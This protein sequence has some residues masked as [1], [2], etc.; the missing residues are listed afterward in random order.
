MLG[1]AATALSGLVMLAPPAVAA[2]AP[3]TDRV[4][5]TTGGF[6]AGSGTGR[7]G[8]ASRQADALSANGRY[9]VIE[10]SAPLTPGVS[11]AP[12]WH[13]FVRDRKLGTTTLASVGHRGQAANG[14]SGDAVISADGR[15]VAFLSEATNLVPGD[16]NARSDVFLRDL[17]RGTTTRVSTSSTGGQLTL[18]GNGTVGASSPAISPDGRYVGFISAASGLTADDETG[19]QAYLKDTVTGALEVVSR[20][21]HGVPAHVVTG[22]SL[23]VS[24]GGRK[25]SFYS[26]DAYLVPGENNHNPD[27]FVRDRV[28]GAT[29]IV[30]AGPNGS[31]NP[32][33]NADGTHVAFIARDTPHLVPGAPAGIDLVYVHELASG[34]TVAASRS[35]AGVWADAHSKGP[36]LSHDGRFVSFNSFAT[37]L[38]P[39]DTNGEADVFRHDTTTGRTIRVSVRSNG[40]QNSLNSSLAAISGNG[41]HVLFES[42]ARDLTQVATTGW[43][44]V[45]VRSVDGSLPAMNARVAALPSRMARKS[46][47]KVSVSGI[48]AGQ[49]LRVVW[50]SGRHKKVQNIPVRARGVKIVA[51]GRAGKHKVSVTYAGRVLRTRTIVVR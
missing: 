40:R 48:A 46:S 39:A 9:V 42:H 7:L 17:R 24:R 19:S 50:K 3:F 20:D 45:F 33:M 26:L 13:I 49:K 47:R 5:V 51:P 38:V 41:M 8:T 44:D 30:P 6:H 10:S 37:N 32:A 14:K 35:S 18:P 25:V 2:P 23:G 27:V 36:T 12:A 29:T 16:T 31:K 21:A 28:A 4:S 11:R 43:G 15:Y 34:T 1:A 22:S